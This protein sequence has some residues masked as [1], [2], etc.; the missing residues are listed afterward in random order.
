MHSAS[1]TSSGSLGGNNCQQQSFLLTCFH[2]RSSSGDWKG[3]W[4]HKRLTSKISLASLLLGM[5][6]SWE[7]T[8]WGLPEPQLLLGKP[9]RESSP[10]EHLGGSLVPSARKA[11]A[12]MELKSVLSFCVLQ[13][14]CR[15]H[16]GT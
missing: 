6:C 14:N 7:R 16:C 8:A 9:K 13:G 12:G 1:Q 2:P 11:R 5:G 4:A 15:L 3:L 10:L